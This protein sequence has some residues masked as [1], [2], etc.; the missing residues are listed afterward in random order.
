M[1]TPIYFLYVLYVFRELLSLRKE[2]TTYDSVLVEIDKLESYQE[3]V[4][5]IENRQNELSSMFGDYYVGVDTDW[6]RLYQALT[7]AKSFKKCVEDYSL[8]RICV[9][10]ICTDAESVKYCGVMFGEISNIKSDLEKPLLWFCSLFE[11]T[12]GFTKMNLIDFANYLASCKNNKHLLEEWVDYRSNLK[13]CEA[14]GLQPFVKQVDTKELDTN[15]IADAYL[16]R[17]YHLWLD[18]MMA[19]F[20]AVRDF[21]GRI[22]EQNIQEFCKLDTEQFRIAQARVR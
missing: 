5:S 1:S 20:P 21:R 18:K 9:N 14:A 19:Q 15:Y 12:S 13:K 2:D 11:D 6:D 3:V 10:K 22:Q 8:S 4:I 16:K 7:F 17:F